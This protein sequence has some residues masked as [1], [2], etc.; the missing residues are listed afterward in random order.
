LELQDNAD[1]EGD[2]GE[3]ESPKNISVSE[4]YRGILDIE[5]HN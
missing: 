5:N 3:D 4:K 1:G 2:N